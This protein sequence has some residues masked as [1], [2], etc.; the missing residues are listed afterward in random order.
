MNIILTVT[1]VT[2]SLR[3]GGGGSV[4][5]VGTLACDTDE[6]KARFSPCEEIQDTLGFCFQVMD[7]GL[8]LLGSRIQILEFGFQLL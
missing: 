6:T 3:G 7:S 4:H 1:S 5:K 8:Q 2:L